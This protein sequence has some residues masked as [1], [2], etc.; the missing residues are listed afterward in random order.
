[1]V[2]A[3]DSLNALHRQGASRYPPVSMSEK[4]TPGVY[5]DGA[6]KNDRVIVTTGN[7]LE[8]YR[9][10]DYLGVVRG[11]VVR[12]PSFSQTMM[13]GLKSIGG[14]NINEWSK[15]CEEARHDAYTLM[16]RHAQQLGADAIIAMRYDATDFMQGGA[17]EVLAYGTAVRVERR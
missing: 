3:A 17:T 14:G 13:G 5:R 8:G 12:S 7:D 16:L 9:I 4:S 15:V 10:V 11:I 1:M 2:L 6:E